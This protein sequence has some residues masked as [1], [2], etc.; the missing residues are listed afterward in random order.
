MAKFEKSKADK[1]S[2][3]KGGSESSKKDM[4]RDKRMMAKSKG[5]KGC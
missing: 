1:K 2:D 3:K 5:K 4:A